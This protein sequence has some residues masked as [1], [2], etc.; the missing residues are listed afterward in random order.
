MINKSDTFISFF[1][2]FSDP[3][4]KLE[5]LA[6]IPPPPIKRGRFRAPDK[7]HALLESTATDKRHCYVQ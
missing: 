2:F 6:A 4:E 1:P 7:L 5:V 3:D